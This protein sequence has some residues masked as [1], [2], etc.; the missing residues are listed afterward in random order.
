MAAFYAC[1]SR[2]PKSRAQCDREMTDE[3][4][5]LCASCCHST[6][7]RNARGSVF[8]LCE[9]SKT[10]PRFE[11]YPRLPVLSC[12]GFQQM[13]LGPGSQREIV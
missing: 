10:D 4:A 1:G 13:D 11:K 9:L 8:R 2:L 5:G 12:S 6:E 3:T 7:V